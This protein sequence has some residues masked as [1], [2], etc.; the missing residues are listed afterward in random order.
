MSEQK[1]Y[2]QE[3]HIHGDVH[4]HLN[5]NKEDQ[6]HEHRDVHV[7]GKENKHQG[8]DRRLKNEYMKMIL[9]SMNQTKGL[10]LITWTYGKKSWGR[11]YDEV[12]Q[13]IGQIRKRIIQLFYQSFKRYKDD[14]PTPEFPKM[15]FFIEEHK[16]GQFHI[17]LLME[18]VDPDLMCKGF[19]NNRFQIIWDRIVNK[20]ITVRSQR[21]QMVITEE[22]VKRFP[23]YK[24]H[25]HYGKTFSQLNRYDGWLVARFICEFITHNNQ[26]NGE[27]WG[28]RKLSNSPTCI[29]S[30]VLESNDEVIQKTDY[31][32]KDKNFRFKSNPALTQDH[33]CVMYS[34]L[35][36]KP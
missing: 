35:K 5:I 31:L 2:P 10:F 23:E 11:H 4:I 34:D 16:D 3:I 30:K 9:E 6:E 21:D 19:H 15:W 27:G 25:P 1:S 17:H 36:E 22:M 29:H 26:R 28:L 8:I 13:D 14:R 32:N 18:S 20:K 7:L 24:N 33:L 12:V